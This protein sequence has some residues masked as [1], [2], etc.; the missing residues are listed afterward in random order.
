V[1]PHAV[2]S[3]LPTTKFPLN[4]PGNNIGIRTSAHLAKKLRAELNAGVVKVFEDNES[5][6]VF[7][8]ELVV[9]NIRQKARMDAQKL[10]G[11]YPAEKYGYD[12]SGSIV[13]ESAIPEPS[14]IE[15]WA[16][17]K[18]EIDRRQAVKKKE[19]QGE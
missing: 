5:G 19:L 2:L 8:K 12:V 7:G 6:A 3:L 17:M 16:K 4:I 10:L 11:L 1:L 15:D 18:E 13:V 14:S 9:W